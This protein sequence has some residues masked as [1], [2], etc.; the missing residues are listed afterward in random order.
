MGLFRNHWPR[1]A[2]RVWGINAPE[3]N[4]AEGRAARDYAKTLLPI[5]GLC[6]V[7]SMGWDKYGGRFDGKIQL[8]DGRDLAEVM[9]Q[10]GFA[11]P[12]RDSVYNRYERF[13]SGGKDAGSGHSIL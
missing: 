13:A 5:N 10:G 2:C 7:I 4:T 12:M 6:K 8:F 11:V 9:L 1:L 3:L